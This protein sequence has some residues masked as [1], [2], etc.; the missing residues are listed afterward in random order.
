MN[1]EEAKS[2][3]LKYLHQ[4]V[5]SVKEAFSK[6]H[7][8]SKCGPQTL[9]IIVTWELVRKANIWASSKTCLTGRSGGGTGQR[10][11]SRLS[12]WF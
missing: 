11:V 7:W 5:S 10:V 9:S 8:F 12:R 1:S 6:A 3:M 2:E 4:Y